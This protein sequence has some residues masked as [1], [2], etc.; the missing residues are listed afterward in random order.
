MLDKAEIRRIRVHDLRHTFASIMI[1]KGG[2]LVYI[3]DQLGHSSIK[4]T[5]DVYGS[6]VKRNDKP[7]D[8]LDGLLHS[9]APHAH[10]ET[11]KDLAQMS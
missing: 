3:K 10:P 2:D 9:N 5:V 4:V 1:S 11:E 7:V 6:M 8:M